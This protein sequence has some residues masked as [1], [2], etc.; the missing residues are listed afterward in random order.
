[1][2]GQG[3]KTT[4]RYTNEPD[5]PSSRPY[6]VVVR[7]GRHDGRLYQL[8]AGSPLL[9]G[10]L[11]TCDLIVP[12]E[13]DSVSRE[14]AE[15]ELHADG[16]VILRLLLSLELVPHE[17]VRDARGVVQRRVTVLVYFVHIRAQFGD[18]ASDSQLSRFGAVRESPRLRPFLG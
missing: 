12:P 17:G 5:R 16:R 6:L 18:D 11:E 8:E 13:D 3:R 4:A 14:H 1:M 7:D 2:S 10:R 15:V 9:L